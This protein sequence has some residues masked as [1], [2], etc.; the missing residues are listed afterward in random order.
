MSELA[1]IMELKAQA[2]IKQKQLAEEIKALE[3]VERMLRAKE[4]SPKV[5]NIQPS[6]YRKLKQEAA[7]RDVLTRAG[8]ALTTSQIADAL[9][10]GGFLFTSKNLANSLYATM[11]KNSKGLYFCEKIG[12]ST[13]FG[14]AQKVEA[15]IAM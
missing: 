15:N 1:G 7:V 13:V 5:V 4:D 6:I 11:K 8:K 12:G 2:Y 9:K 3:M 14:L 10:E